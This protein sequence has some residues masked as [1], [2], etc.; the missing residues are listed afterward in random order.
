MN[1]KQARDSLSDLISYATKQRAPLIKYQTILTDLARVSV[2]QGTDKERLF[3]IRGMVLNALDKTV[4]EV[5]SIDEVLG[6]EKN[7]TKTNQ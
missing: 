7:E 2:G 5:E 6:G 1:E 3:G 4:K